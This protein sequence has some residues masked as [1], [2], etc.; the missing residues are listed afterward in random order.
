MIRMTTHYMTGTSGNVH[1]AMI[2]EL[3]TSKADSKRLSVFC[4]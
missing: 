1:L 2:T 3:D 4:R